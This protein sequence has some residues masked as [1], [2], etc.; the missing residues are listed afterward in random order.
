MHSEP[1]RSKQW[2]HLIEFVGSLDMCFYIAAG[3]P[4][5]RSSDSGDYVIVQFLEKDPVLNTP[6]K[7]LSTVSRVNDRL[8][9]VENEQPSAIQNR[10]DQVDG[11][12]H[13]SEFR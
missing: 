9:E 1:S 11:C 10:R 2:V 5:Y 13:L 4:K 6:P 3:K 12:F 8:I 7:L